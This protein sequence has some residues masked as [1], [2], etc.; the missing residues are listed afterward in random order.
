GSSTIFES[1]D[2]IEKHINITNNKVYK[3]I[4]NIILD[5]G[6]LSS[7]K[8]GYSQGEIQLL[9]LLHVL[10]NKS[11]IILLD[12]TLTSVQKTLKNNIYQALMT[13]KVA[14]I[15]IDH[16]LEEEIKGGFDEIILF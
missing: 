6:V 12:E 7:A 10:A 13:E 15:L 8:H 16:T 14:V 3:N 2:K 4:R 5:S 1:I 11:S 9:S